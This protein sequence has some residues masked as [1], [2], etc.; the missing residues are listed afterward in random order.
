MVGRGQSEEHAV[1]GA[2][3]VEDAVPMSEQLRMDRSCPGITVKI[4]MCPSAAG[5]AAALASPASLILPVPSQDCN[6]LVLCLNLKMRSP[7]PTRAHQV[8]EQVQVIGSDI[9]TQEDHSSTASEANRVA[10]T[11]QKWDAL[12]LVDKGTTVRVKM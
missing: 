9:L 7:H 1:L 6:A 8:Y 10:R 4:A 11:C 3:H 12:V 5:D 2:S